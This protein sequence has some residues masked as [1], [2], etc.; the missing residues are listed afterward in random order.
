LKNGNFDSA[1]S[2]FDKLADLEPDNVEAYLGRARVFAV[3]SNYRDALD[4]CNTVISLSPE[5][6]EALIL[7]N[8]IVQKMHYSMGIYS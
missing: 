3:W 2:V 8:S 7:R 5:L 6:E 1:Y 4:D